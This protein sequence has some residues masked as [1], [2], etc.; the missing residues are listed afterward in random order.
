MPTG[1]YLSDR[2]RAQLPL[3]LTGAARRAFSEL[4]DDHGGPPREFPFRRSAVSFLEVGLDRLE[5]R[6]GEVVDQGVLGAR[7]IFE[8]FRNLP[9]GDS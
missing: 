7:G 9:G 2:H 1:R 4:A 3:P 5:L 8:I 6:L